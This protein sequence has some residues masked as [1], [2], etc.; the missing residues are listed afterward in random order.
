[1]YWDQPRF[2]IPGSV[3]LVEEMI[4]HLPKSPGTNW[5]ESW[6]QDAI[7]LGLRKQRGDIVH[8]VA[9]RY[10]KIFDIHDPAF[11]DRKQCSELEEV[12][13]L[14]A[15]FLH[16][17]EEDTEGKLDLSMFF[18][19]ECVVRVIRL[20]LHGAS[21]IQTGRHSSKSRKS[22]TQM[23]HIKKVTLSLL[24]FAAT[25]KFV[26]SGKPS[27]DE[28]GQPGGVNYSE[29][30]LARLHILEEVYEADPQVYHNLITYH[31]RA[32]FADLHYDNEEEVPEA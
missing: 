26:L 20:L 14:M 24:A 21:A 13:V 29:Y 32:A 10:E 30:F 16:I 7:K 15:N 31:N 5:L 25:I 3:D 1:M 23:W 12:Q 2:S 6:F 18:R 22:H 11:E 27:F 17:G 8:S 28:A 4:F 9:K 19:D